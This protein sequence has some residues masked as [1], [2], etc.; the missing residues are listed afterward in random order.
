MD[1]M[2]KI[3]GQFIAA[4]RRFFSIQK[5]KL[6][7]EKWPIFSPQSGYVSTDKRSLYLFN[8]QRPHSGIRE[9]QINLYNTVGISIIY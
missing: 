1:V 5:I 9:I 4:A 2:D 7:V 8:T 3:N 6:S